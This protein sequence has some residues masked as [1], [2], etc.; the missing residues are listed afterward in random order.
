[1]ARST[2]PVGVSISRFATGYTDEGHGLDLMSNKGHPRCCPACG[3]R[4]LPWGMWRVSIWTCIS[5]PKCDARLTR[6]RDFQ[7]FALPLPVILFGIAGIIFHLSPTA[8]LTV[9][10]LVIVFIM[11]PLDVLTVRLLPVGKWRGWWRGYG[12]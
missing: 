4:F 11:W 1:M 5:C 9:G 12:T 2:R 10:A 6:R 8:F 3:H 7:F